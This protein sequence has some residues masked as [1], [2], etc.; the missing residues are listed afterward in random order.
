MAHPQGAL[1]PD[2]RDLTHLDAIDIG[3]RVVGAGKA[4]KRQ[5]QIAAPA[6][7]IA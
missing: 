4:R 3:D 7:H 5:S 2:Q 6:R 1:A